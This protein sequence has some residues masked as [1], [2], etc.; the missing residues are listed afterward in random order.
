[1]K[2]RISSSSVDY[3]VFAL[4]LMLPVLISLYY[5]LVRRQDSAVQFATGGK[6]LAV[7]PAGFSLAVTYLSATLIT[8]KNLHW[9][10]CGAFD[11]MFV[12]RIG[13]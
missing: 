3:A 7:V 13:G 8:G 12:T 11:A 5:A 10:V 6:K 1:M 4:S 9:S 2:E